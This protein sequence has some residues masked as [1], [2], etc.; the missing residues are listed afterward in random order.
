MIESNGGRVLVNAEVEKIITKGGKAT[1]VQIAK[2]GDVISAPFTVSGAGAEATE[3]LL[4][5]WSGSPKEDLKDGISHVYLFLGIDGSAED[6]DLPS[7]NLWALPSSDVQGDLDK[8]YSNPSKYLS[9]GSMLQF[10]GFP[11][12]K[13]PEQRAKGK[14]TCVVISEAKSSWFEEWS[15][16]EQGRRGEEYEDKKKK[17]RFCESQSNE[18]RKHGL[19]RERSSA[20][21]LF[22]TSPLPTLD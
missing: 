4:N 16:R 15:S 6:L 2:S 7:S 1:G 14:S 17:V 13:D 20:V 19:F 11:S 12:A 3:V 10:I 5:G 18:L 22:I 8:Y 9:N 21:F